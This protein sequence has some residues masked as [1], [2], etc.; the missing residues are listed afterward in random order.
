MPNHLNSTNKKHMESESPSKTSYLRINKALNR[1]KSS[2]TCE[3]SDKESDL[4]KEAIDNNLKI[5]LLTEFSEGFKFIE[6]KHVKGLMKKAPASDYTYGETPW[7]PP[8]E[9]EILADERFEV[10]GVDWIVTSD[11]ALINEFSE[12]TCFIPKNVTIEG[13]ELKISKSR[14]LSYIDRP[15]NSDGIGDL[16]YLAAIEMDGVDYFVVKDLT[17]SIFFDDV[18][19]THELNGYTG[20]KYCLSAD[21]A[22]D[23][24]EENIK[25]IT[26]DELKTYESN[27]LPKEVVDASNTLVQKLENLKL[28]ADKATTGLEKDNYNAEIDSLSPDFSK[29]NTLPIIDL[30]HSLP[31]L[32]TNPSIKDRAKRFVWI[33]DLTKKKYAEG[34]A[35]ASEAREKELDRLHSTT[36]EIEH[37]LSLDVEQLE[38]LNKREIDSKTRTLESHP[39]KRNTDENRIES[40]KKFINYLAVSAKSHGI[41][42]DPQNLRCSKQDLLGELF[43]WEKDRGVPKAERLWNVGEFPK[44]TWEHPDR[45]G[46]CNNFSDRNNKPDK[47]FFKK[48]LGKNNS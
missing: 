30:T 18:E 41:E 16:E 31:P 20:V 24:I 45:K 6:A 5:H 13:E 12:G 37:Q 11:D 35:L 9:L 14:W 48:I 32:P 39:L 47:Y 29:A 17:E 44:K 38:L 2:R 42:F 23:S 28:K 46:I 1:F 34:E 8:S 15:D 33:R 4:V 7:L 19:R 25:V 27:H 3:V 21:I 26:N 22:D 43:I 36:K 40:L 10:E